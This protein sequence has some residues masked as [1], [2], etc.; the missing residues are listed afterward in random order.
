MIMIDVVD[1]GSDIAINSVS[2]PFMD[3]I[4]FISQMTELYKI[5]SNFQDIVV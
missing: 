4:A 2:L 5:S 1:I 3:Y